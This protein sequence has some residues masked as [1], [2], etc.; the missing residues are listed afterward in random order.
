MFGYFAPHLKHEKAPT[1]IRH[2]SITSMGVM[3]RTAG[4]IRGPRACALFP[5]AVKQQVSESCQ[6]INLESKQANRARIRYR[7]F[8]AASGP[9]H[10]QQRDSLICAYKRHA[11]WWTPYRGGFNED[12]TDAGYRTPSN[13]LLTLE[14]CRKRCPR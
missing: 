6:V 8:I 11:S 14:P 4:R 1:N 12:E 7:G 2:S 5:A 3:E 9:R 13:Y 10:P